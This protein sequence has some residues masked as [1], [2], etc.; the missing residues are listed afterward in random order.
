MSE[1]RAIDADGHVTEYEVDWAARL[2]AE[3]R[4]RAPILIQGDVDGG[5]P[6]LNRTNA[7]LIDGYRFPDARFEGHGRW[8]T[9][10]VP[11]AA[12]PAGMHDPLQRLPDMDTEGIDVAVLYGTRIA[13]FAN[14]T[15]DWRY[16]QALCRAWN[17]WAAEYCA[18]DRARLK[19]AAL[20]PM[21]A[22]NAPGSSP[23]G[24]AVPGAASSRASSSSS[25]QRTRVT[26]TGR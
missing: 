11:I 13:F 14:S 9:G 10:R 17:D 20:V 5:D 19:F 2:P 15:N 23:A 21:Y 16:A 22:V 4:G 12:N 6:G 26:R 7:M 25:G 18:G 3:L 24:P 1:Y 8:A